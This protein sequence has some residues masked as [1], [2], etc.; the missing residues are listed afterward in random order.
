MTV[1]LGRRSICWVEVTDTFFTTRGDRTI[2]SALKSRPVCRKTPKP[3]DL[4][5]VAAGAT[6]INE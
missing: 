4:V 3:T 5:S 2:D 1:A 6:D